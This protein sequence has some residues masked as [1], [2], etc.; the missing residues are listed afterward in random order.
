M[1]TEGGEEHGGEAVNDFVTFLG[2]EEGGC[3]LFDG[4]FVVNRSVGF[5]VGFD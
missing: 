5:G 1:E 2:S 4:C 3:F